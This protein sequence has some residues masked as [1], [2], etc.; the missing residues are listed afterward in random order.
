M[1]KVYEL[2]NCVAMNRKYP[3]TF[4]IQCGDRV[5]FSSHHIASIF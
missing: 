1:K 5:E 2:E 3:D 4:H